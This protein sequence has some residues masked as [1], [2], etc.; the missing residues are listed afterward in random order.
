[1]CTED[2]LKFWVDGWVDGRTVNLITIHVL[3]KCCRYSSRK[4]SVPL[5]RTVDKDV[6]RMNKSRGIRKAG[7]V[8]RIEER[9]SLYRVLVGE[10]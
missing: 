4:P 3:Y 7:H 6:I 8:A 10:T 9:R 1:V 2:L 5:S